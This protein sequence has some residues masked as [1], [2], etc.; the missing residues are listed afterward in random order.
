LA[1]SEKNNEEGLSRVELISNIFGLFIA[2]H[3]T[4]AT[5]LSAVS[6]LM[7]AYPDLQEKLFLEMNEHIGTEKVPTLE[8]LEK[9]TY[10]NQFLEESLRLY[11]SGILPTRKATED[12]VY[13]DIIIPKG[14]TVGINISAIHENPNYWENP[15]EFDPDRFSV[16]NK[17]GRNNFAYMPFSLGPRQCIGNTFSLIEQKLFVVRLLQKFRVLNPK[18]FPPLDVKQKIRFAQPLYI[19]FERR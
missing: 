4:T 10:L 5:A 16:E 13:K 3:E 17:K 15:E 11:V 1:G 18:S 7:R 6:N 14:V 8:E 12:I 2:G 9:L 19:A